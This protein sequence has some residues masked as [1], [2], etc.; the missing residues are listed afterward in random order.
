MNSYCTFVYIHLTMHYTSRT[1]NGIFFLAET[2]SSVQTSQVEPDETRKIQRRIWYNLNESSISDRQSLYQTGSR[3]GYCV[4]LNLNQR[5]IRQKFLDF[6]KQL[7]YVN[8]YQ[9]KFKKNIKRFNSCKQSTG[10]FYCIIFV[11][12]TLF[13]VARVVDWSTTPRWRFYGRKWCD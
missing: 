2:L 10:S 11:V 1:R 7:I 3:N 12:I 6:L 5:E 13:H 8:N 9:T 4:H